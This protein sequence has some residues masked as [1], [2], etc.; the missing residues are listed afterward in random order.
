MK[1]LRINHIKEFKF[2]LRHG[3]FIS[4]YIS[5]RYYFSILL[6]VHCDEHFL[7]HF[8]YNFCF[9]TGFTIYIVYYYYYCYYT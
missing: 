5:S 8:G 2:K 7:L 1:E 9:I 4:I 3:K 6:D